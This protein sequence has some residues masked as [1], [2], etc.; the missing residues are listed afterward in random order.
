MCS[1][2]IL[3]NDRLAGGMGGNRTVAHDDGEQ[4]ANIYTLQNSINSPNQ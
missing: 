2:Y 1:L 4:P 3:F